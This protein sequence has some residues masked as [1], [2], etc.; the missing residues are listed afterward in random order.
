MP[1]VVLEGRISLDECRRDLVPFIVRDGG[2]LAKGE[3]LFRDGEDQTLLIETLVVDRG[4][5]QKFF[6]QVARRPEGAIVRLEPLTDPE[7]TPGVRRALAVV[8]KRI[9]DR[10]GARYGRS[11]IEEFLIP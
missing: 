2:F 8:A 3:R 4:H 1:H 6:I 10:T 11:N 9:R 5:T 7:K